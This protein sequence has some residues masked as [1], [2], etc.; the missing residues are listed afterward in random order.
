MSSSLPESLPHPLVVGDIGGT[1]ARFALVEEPGAPLQPLPKLRTGDF[2]GPAEAIRSLAGSLPAQPRS[3]VMC[4]AGP[5]N[6]RTCSLTN[7][8]WLID[9]PQLAGALG[10]ADGLL[11]NDFEAQALS[12]PAIPA[13]D[14]WVIGPDLKPGGGAKVVLGPGTGLGVGALVQSAGR[15]IPIPSEGGHIDLA[16]GDED[17]ASV[18]AHLQRVGGRIAGEVVLSGPGLERLHAARMAALARPAAVTTAAGIVERGLVD[19]Q[20]D[21][22]AT[23][24]MFL[25]ILARFAGDMAITFGATGGVFFAGGILPRLRPVLDPAMFRRT[26]E[27]KAPVEWLPRSIGTRMVVSDRAVLHGM[28][29]IAAQPARYEIDYATRSWTA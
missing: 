16:P 21:E 13:D 4:G 20:G 29:A 25:S 14:L 23:V 24:R 27:A 11:L 3:V 5:V 7:A 15:H 1:N 19:R 18:F 22:G 9:G 6:G 12:L 10:L 26:F 28:A 2:P 17:E 8:P